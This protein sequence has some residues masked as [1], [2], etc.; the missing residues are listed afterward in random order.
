MLA[1]CGALA[2]A[3]F[4][5]GLTASAAHASP[6]VHAHRGGSVVEGVPSFGENTMAAFEHS[7]A[8]GY[9]LELDVKLSSDAVPIVLHDATLDRTT[10]CTGAVAAKTA[11]E[12]AACRVD[13]LG[14]SGNSVQLEAGDP[15][16]EP[17]PTLAE[18]LAFARDAGAVINLEIKNI[19]IDPDFDGTDGFANAVVDEVIASGFP[20][21]RLIVQS[22]WPPNLAV[23]EMRIATADTSLLTFQE[24]NGLPLPASDGGPA[25]ADA[26]GFE[27][28][29]P[30]WSPSA[31]VIGEA[32]GLG[33]QVVPYTLNTEDE[34]GDAFDRGVD[35]V[36][37]DD[38]AMARRVIA[39]KEPD[40]P[41]PSPPPSEAE[42]AASQASRTAAPIEAYQPV[43]GAPRVFAIQF[44]QEL[45][46][47]TSY[48][49]FRT[50]I[51]CLIRDHVVPRMTPDRPNV[52]ALTED[53]GLMTIA[54]GSRG[55]GARAIFA[56]PDTAPGC[57]GAGQ[58]CGALGALG[59]VT[60]AYGTQ[61][62]AYQTRFVGQMQPVSSAFVAAT[63]T[64]ARGWMQTF[65]DIARRYGVYILGSNN[66]TPFRQSRDPSE[67]PVFADPDLPAP[68]SVFVSTEP[69][70]YNEVFMWGPENVRE[71]GP[72]P[73]RNAVAQNKKVPLTPIEEQLQLS[74]GPSTGPDAIENL[75]P[76][77]LPGTGARI[78]FATSKPAF[79]YDGADSPTSF[80]QPLDAAIDPCADTAVHYMRC[81]DRLGTNL[82]MQDEANAGVWTGDSGEGNFTPLEWNRS[83]WRT[84]ADPSVDFDYNVTPFMVGNLADLAFDGQTSI[85]QRGLDTGPGCNY[86]GVSAF[87][88]GPP[89][90]DPP[91]LE[92]YAGPKTEFVA[93][94]PW[95]ASDGPRHE[96]RATGDRLTQGSGD[97][98]EN[99]YVETSIAADLPFPPRPRDSCAT[100]AAVAG[101]GPGNGPGDGIVGTVS[102]GACSNRIVGTRSANRLRGT[103]G[104]DL[105]AGRGGA[106]RIHARG[107]DDCVK[108]NRGRDRIS[109][110]TGD[111]VLH[112]NKGR[113]V[114]KGRKGRDRI[115][116]GNHNDILRAR[117][118]E[119]DLVNCGAGRRD[120]AIVD[121]RDRATSNCEI[122]R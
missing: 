101:A 83:T 121:A 92:V 69:T 78:G 105:L 51:E 97:R 87:M 82:V 43:A 8:E 117:D 63:D 13:I 59:A 66:Q 55:A 57:N 25:V 38:P 49:A 20:P 80:G 23:V 5:F 21:S 1:R 79:E 120:V 75:R 100:G 113:D 30:Q 3:L 18:L 88:R 33:L 24:V 110:G 122:V 60:A 48:E 44:K 67:I 90:N 119:R 7:A 37:S 45:R 2:V 94:A 114:I 115:F 22:F 19:P 32:H 34:I 96:L 53:V 102:A 29:S 11:A 72:R 62:A 70:V 93:I 36:I 116:G 61:A 39:V 86:V 47:V 107:G 109:G 31:A 76:Y 104:S 111:D 77:D 46:H 10:D 9:V 118:G 14:T 40:P 103:G 35:A 108:G 58:P 71:E 41:P 42:C 91:H 27:W 6:Y 56:N 26:A 95:V 112:G 52:V 98:L 81:L 50:K 85:T 15:R 64:F 74:P 65:S 16:L 4:V 99:D 106:D 54:T 73:L 12:L 89:E 84:A 68:E 17:V 28:V